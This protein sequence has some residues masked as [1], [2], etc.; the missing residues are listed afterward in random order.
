MDLQKAITE[1]RAFQRQYLAIIS[2]RAPRKRKVSVWLALGAGAGATVVLLLC[3][4]LAAPAQNAF[5][6]AGL[7]TVGAVFFFACFSAIAIIAQLPD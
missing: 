1:C 4:W 6:M 5:G 3:F 7:F 2:K